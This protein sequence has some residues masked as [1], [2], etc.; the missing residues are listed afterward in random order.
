M[1]KPEMCTQAGCRQW[2]S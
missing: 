2:W 1:R